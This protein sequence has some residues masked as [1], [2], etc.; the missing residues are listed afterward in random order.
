M[1]LLTT[2]DAFGKVRRNQVDATYQLPADE[3]TGLV[4]VF[5]IVLDVYV[6]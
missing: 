3:R 6:G 2:V 1:G 4:E 5:G